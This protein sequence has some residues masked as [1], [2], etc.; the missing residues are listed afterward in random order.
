[1]FP[2][3][4]ILL[5]FS[6]AA[7]LYKAFKDDPELDEIDDKNI[8]ENFLIKQDEEGLT[9]TTIKRKTT[10]AIN[11][12][13]SQYK[14]YKIGKSGNPKGR[15]KGID[16][17]KYTAMYVL[18]M[19]KDKVLIDRLEGYYNTKYIKDKKNNNKKEG[20]AGVTTD[21]NGRHYLYIAVR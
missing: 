11:T 21:S 7:M 10:R 20:S 8:Y 5:L 12:I 6:G 16:Y 3:I 18:C 13:V 9:E 4:P 19:S 17:R 14:G 1:M 2:L 15:K